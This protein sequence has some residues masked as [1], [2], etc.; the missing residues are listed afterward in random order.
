MRTRTLTETT[1]MMQA[2]RNVAICEAVAAG[3]R[4]LQE[5][6]DEY[7]LR[8][9]SA[10][11]S[12]KSKGI[13]HWQEWQRKADE[14]G[15]SSGGTPADGLG[16]Q[17][18]PIDRIK[19]NPWQPR[20][21]IK[22]QTI[23]SRARDIFSNGL[24]SPV[25]VRP[26]GDDYELVY[27]QYRLLSFRRL[28]SLGW[29]LRD[30]RDDLIYSLWPDEYYDGEIT[31][32]PAIVR[33]MSDRELILASIGENTQRE[34]LSWLDE[35]R[36][37]RQALDADPGLHQRRLAEVIGISPSN[38]SERLSML[39]LP[40]S[41][42]EAVDAGDMAW[43]TA[44]MLLCFVSDYE[45]H[46]HTD[47]IEQVVS[48]ARVSGLSARN[49]S[50]YIGVV[51]ERL[52]QWR[53]IE[54]GMEDRYLEQWGE[55]KRWRHHLP[56]LQGGQG[57]LWYTCRADL[58]DAQALHQM[59][60]SPADPILS[61]NTLS[62]ANP[63]TRLLLADAPEETAPPPEEPKSD[64]IE[65]WATLAT[66]ADTHPAVE[67]LPFEVAELLHDGVISSGFCVELSRFEDQAHTHDRELRAI[68]EWIG[69]LG[70]DLNDVQAR[71]ALIRMMSRLQFRSM[72]DRL[73]AIGFMSPR[74]GWDEWAERYGNTWTHT[75]VLPDGNEALICCATKGWDSLQ[76]FR[77]RQI[78]EQVARGNASSEA[79]AGQTMDM[80]MAPAADEGEN[81]S[82]PATDA[83]LAR[84][85]RQRLRFRTRER[86]A[87]QEL[88]IRV[89]LDDG[90]WTPWV[91]LR[92][93]IEVA[94]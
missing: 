18:I 82:A 66:L 53:G 63:Y 8:S 88:E 38:V 60:Q 76:E 22:Q 55:S 30:D 47:A 17:M 80:T 15:A 35:T 85:Q 19:P 51:V 48:M 57:S 50:E 68:A 4:T 75:I 73:T 1:W 89:S 65:V 62:N 44:R 90:H 28:D 20:Q 74:F 71:G 91:V 52:I 64:P 81:S 39:H 9:K 23:Y 59:A 3:G 11:H 5:I 84:P 33:T 12:I 21:T 78:R 70:S 24:L 32:I 37:M 46:D 2:E 86:H 69:G 6:A 49:V 93:G 7:G 43:T 27:G 67:R 72:D 42:L 13:E 10:V 77:D 31:R 26:A 14:A 41:V 94:I 36:A 16:I 87:G 92:D 54:D 25:L 45:G 61:E 83:D 40:D 79:P 56:V 34:D 29:R 58:I